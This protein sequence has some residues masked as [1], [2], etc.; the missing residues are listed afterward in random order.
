VKTYC[1]IVFARGRRC[2]YAVR[3]P[4][5]ALTL[6]SAATTASADVFTLQTSIATP[7]TGIVNSTKSGNTG[8]V[9]TSNGGFGSLASFS[10]VAGPGLLTA[11][12]SVNTD[13]TNGEPPPSESA[14]SIAVATMELDNIVF[15][16][17]SGPFLY[18]VNYSISG[19]I[20]LSTLLFPDVQGGVGL[21]YLS[22]TA[23]ILLGALRVDTDINDQASPVGIFAGYDPTKPVI[24]ISVSASTPAVLGSFTSDTSIAFTLATDAD[25]Q[26]Y[27]G[28]SADFIVNFQDPFS[29]PTTG[30]V[31]NFF[32][33]TTGAPLTGITANSSDGC[34]VNN[35]FM[36]GSESTPGSV[37]ELSSWTMM[38]A[39][40]AG[41]GYAGWRR[42]RRQA[43]APIGEEI[44][45]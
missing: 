4:I 24:S 14:L 25:A 6:A 16:G 2:R 21:R 5:A 34:I 17:G 9:E 44:G 11:S 3:G 29:L 45:L 37:P 28:S 15:S 10:A 20:T 23:D 35:V 22:G 1:A 33:P 36:C 40:F 8:P 38:L 7:I 30:P 42:G 18:S 19:T 39:G 12:S 13:F 41:L 32:D 26:S 27:P 43:A 31:F